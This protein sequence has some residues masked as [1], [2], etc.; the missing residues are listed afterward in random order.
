MEKIKVF[1]IYKHDVHN[2]W[3]QMKRIKN[4]QTTYKFYA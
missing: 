1:K 2:T 4:K 3:L